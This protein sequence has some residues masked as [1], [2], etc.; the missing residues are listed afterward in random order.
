MEKVDLS[1]Y[2][3]TGILGTGADYEARAAVE[4]ETGRQVVLKRPMPQ[5]VRHQLHAGIEARTDRI[6]QAYRE[7]GHTLPTVVP[8]LGYTDRA[9]HDAY[10]G[11]EFGPGACSARRTVIGVDRRGCVDQLASN[12]AGFPAIRQCATELDHPD[13]KSLGAVLKGLG[14]HGR[15]RRTECAASP[16]IK[17]IK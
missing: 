11:D 9:N 14:I 17:I 5:T 4:R 16:A 1:R 15:V 2:E 10:F 13:R 6:L 8:I 3:A 7:V 12:P